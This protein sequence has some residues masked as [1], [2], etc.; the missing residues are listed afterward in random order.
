MKIARRQKELRIIFPIV[1]FGISSE[2]G[3]DPAATLGKLIMKSTKI[4]IFLLLEQKFPPR[5]T[6]C[7]VSLLN[8]CT[9]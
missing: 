1:G 5:Q 2:E 6:H 4:F 9:L 8:I 7:K 3:K